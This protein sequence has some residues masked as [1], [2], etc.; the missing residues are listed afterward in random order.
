MEFSWDEVTKSTFDSSSTLPSRSCT[1]KEALDLAVNIPVNDKGITD[2][3]IDDLIPVCPDSADNIEWA[4]AAVPLILHIIGREVSSSEPFARDN[5]LSEEKAIVEGG[6]S[7]IQ[8]VLGWV[9]NTS[10]LTIGL[11]DKKFTEWSNDIKHTLLCSYICMQPLEILKGH[12]N[13]VANIMQAMRHFL[14]CLW[15]LNKQ[16]GRSKHGSVSISPEVKEDLLLF[17][18]FLK[19]THWGISIN[20]VAYHKTTHV[21][22][23][24]A[25]EHGIGGIHLPQG[26]LSIFGCQLT[27]FSKYPWTVWSLLQLW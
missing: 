7:E 19:V 3:Y 6:M 8:T 15:V 21:Y 12:L 13:H 4:S 22:C 26:K 5:L 14:N 1:F 10:S 2:V 11:T 25:L 9:I 20:I 18:D 23:S 16:A 27:V 24:D 17:L